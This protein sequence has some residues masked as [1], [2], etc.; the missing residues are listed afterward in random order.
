M[1]EHHLVAGNPGVRQH[2]G[3]GLR[4]RL[5]DEWRTQLPRADRLVVTAVCAALMTAYGYPVLARE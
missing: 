1:G 4:L 3:S 5:D 2:A